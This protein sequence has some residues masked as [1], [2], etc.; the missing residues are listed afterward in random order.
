ML[1]IR[2]EDE[3][4]SDTNSNLNSLELLDLAREAMSENTVKND[5]LGSPYLPT[6]GPSDI[7]IPI[8]ED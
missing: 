8:C 6:V 5:G 3:T 2:I 1:F 4:E 7:K